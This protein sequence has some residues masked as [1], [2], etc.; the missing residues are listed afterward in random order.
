MGGLIA[1]RILVNVSCDGKSY[2]FVVCFVGSIPI[3]DEFRSFSE[4]PQGGQA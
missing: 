1:F 3:R 2:F 4:A